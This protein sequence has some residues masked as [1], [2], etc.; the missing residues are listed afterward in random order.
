MSYCL[1]EYRFYYASTSYKFL[2]RCVGVV[3]KHLPLNASRLQYPLQVVNT[4]IAEGTHIGEGVVSFRPEKAAGQRQAF[5]ST[6]LARSST[7]LAGVLLVYLGMVR[8]REDEGIRMVFLS[9]ARGW[10]C[11]SI[12]TTTKP[13]ISTSWD[14]LAISPQSTTPA[15]ATA[16]QRHTFTGPFC[17]DDLA[18]AP[19]S[20]DPP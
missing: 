1:E 5:W 6:T 18:S 12:A 17:N 16:I 13:R 15:S 20:F 7:S 8:E 2:V 9:S 10:S 3:I 4:M 19:Q 14:H 11:V